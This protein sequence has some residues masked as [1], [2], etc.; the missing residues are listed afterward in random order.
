MK[1]SIIIPSYKPESYILD[2][3]NSIKSQTL[4][5]YLY[6]FII[7]LNGPKEPYYSTIKHFK[8]NNTYIYY[9]EIPGVSNARNIGLNHAN[10]EY[11][12]FIDDDDIIS[13]SYLE[14]LLHVAGKNTLAISNVYSFINNINEKRENFFIC[15][16][17]RNKKK[18]NLLSHYH[19]RSFLSFPVAKLIHRDIIG[20]H[21][22]DVRFKNGE[23]SLFIT[24]ISNKIIDLKFTSDDAIY[25]VRERIGSASRK[26]IPL[27]KL[28]ID[29]FNLI[30]TYIIVYLKSP[31]SYSFLLFLSRIPGVIKNAYCLSLNK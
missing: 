23:D 29:S 10:G 18:I 25:Y 24:S 27:K 21:R 31:K 2:C 17:M 11:I 19:C 26:K 8:S 14:K 22:Y 20:T 1:I 30:V 5:S 6:E 3:I 15:K 4:P 28:I 9:T 7:V 16:K 12:C 13:V